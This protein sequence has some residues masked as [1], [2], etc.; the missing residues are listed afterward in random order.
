[1]RR[2][3]TRLTVMPAC[4]LSATISSFSATDQRRRRSGPVKISAFGYELV[5]DTT[6]LLTLILR[7]GRVWT[8]RGLP[9]VDPIWFVGICGDAMMSANISNAL[10]ALTASDSSVAPIFESEA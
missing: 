5:I 8:I 1:M 2:R 6:L 4:R 9:A 10:R 3:A 7:V